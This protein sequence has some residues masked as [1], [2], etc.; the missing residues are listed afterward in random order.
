M[1]REK[2]FQSVEGL[3]T[4]Y[5]EIMNHYEAAFWIHYRML[6]EAI[7][8]WVKEV[9]DNSDLPRVMYFVHTEYMSMVF[10]E[11][12]LTIEVL[13]KAELT[14]CKTNKRYG[15]CIVPMLDEMMTTDDNRCNSI[16]KEFE[17][18]REVFDKTDSNKS[19][20]NVR[21]IDYD[22]VMLDIDTASTI[23]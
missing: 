15:H 2:Q 19:F 11:M 21:Y 7:K 1:E 17:K 18:F 16:A 23:K 13:F 22:K 6:N 10:S 12:L 4:W 8:T 20:V 14:R 3:I 5:D 9:D